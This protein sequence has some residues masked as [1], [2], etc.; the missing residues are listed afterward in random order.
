M[1]RL[2]PTECSC[3]FSGRTME[4]KKKNPLRFTNLFFYRSLARQFRAFLRA[5]NTSR[6]NA[7][8]G[9]SLPLSLPLVLPSALRPCSK[10]ASRFRFDDNRPGSASTVKE[11]FAKRGREGERKGGS[12]RERREWRSSGAQTRRSAIRACRNWKLIG[13]ALSR[14][15]VFRARR[16]YMPAFRRRSRAKRSERTTSDGVLVHSRSDKSK[17]SGAISAGR[18]DRSAIFGV[19]SV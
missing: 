1:Y 17:R 8:N 12:R 9:S 14:E 18:A 16:E 13:F 4:E 7:E 10:I 6:E 2:E 19:F 5:F 3:L 11:R 15:S